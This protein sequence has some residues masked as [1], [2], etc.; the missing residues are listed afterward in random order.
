QRLRPWEIGLVEAVLGE[1]LR[2]YGYEL[3]GAP[4]PSAGQ[5][6]RYELATGRH[7]LA[8]SGGCWARWGPGGRWPR[9]RRAPRPGSG[10]EPPRWPR[11]APGAS[12]SAGR[13]PRRHA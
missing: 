6:L 10:G 13:R 11:T 3:S 2:A 5:R 1:R 8:L 9:P 4:E 12:G 7:R